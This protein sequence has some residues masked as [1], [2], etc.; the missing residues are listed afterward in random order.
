V[1]SPRWVNNKCVLRLPQSP[2]WFPGWRLAFPGWLELCL[3]HFP[4]P[5][6]DRGE[7]GIFCR[8]PSFGEPRRGPPNF[9]AKRQSPA[10]TK[11][12]VP[13][14][15]GFTSTFSLFGTT[16]G[17]LSGN[18]FPQ[19]SLYNSTVSP[20]VSTSTATGRSCDGRFLPCHVLS[21][22]WAAKP[23]GHFPPLTM[24]VALFNKS[25]GPR[26]PPPALESHCV[27]PSPPP[28]LL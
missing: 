28:A 4:L 24:F 11:A 12:T 14:C 21:V 22:L 15:P 10:P 2:F 20:V 16:L 27:L 19:I 7:G 17:C 1:G 8:I 9:H 26:Q 18:F 13:L 5:N 6:V 25:L 23:V 3:H